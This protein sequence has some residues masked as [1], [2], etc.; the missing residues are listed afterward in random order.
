[1]LNC[2]SPGKS[3]TTGRNRWEKNKVKIFLLVLGIKENTYCDLV[4]AVYWPRKSYKFSISSSFLEDSDFTSQWGLRVV[5]PLTLE[6]KYSHLESQL[7][8]EAEALFLHVYS[9][10]LCAAEPPPWAKSLP[11][12]ISTLAVVNIQTQPETIAPEF[13]GAFHKLLSL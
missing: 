7:V 13:W 2:L 4:N 3:I 5:V 1:M 12:H 8:T 9:S 6:V 11:P 10:S